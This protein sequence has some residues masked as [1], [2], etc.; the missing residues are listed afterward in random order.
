MVE[1]VLLVGCL[2]MAAMLMAEAPHQYYK[3]CAAPE[4][5]SLPLMAW[6]TAY[7]K[8]ESVG[9]GIQN[10]INAQMQSTENGT[11]LNHCL[12]LGIGLDYLRCAGQDK[13]GI[14]LYTGDPLQ[15]LFE[16]TGLFD[17]CNSIW[18][19]FDESETEVARR[20][21]WQFITCERWA[22]IFADLDKAH[23]LSFNEKFVS[24]PRWLRTSLTTPWHASSVGLPRTRQHTQLR[25]PKIGRA[26]V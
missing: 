2:A 15:R 23:S 18:N 10:D 25:A 6:V 1:G 11:I 24:H 4:D 21:V 16:R 19:T 14:W 20:A 17:E 3:T 22:S 26:H 7:L 5:L 13:H 12:V 8:G 9:G